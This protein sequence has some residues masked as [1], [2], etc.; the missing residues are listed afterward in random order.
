MK[1]RVLITGASGLLGR[2]LVEYSASGWDVRAMTHADLDVSDAPAVAAALESIRPQ[3]VIN[4]AALS[5]VDQCE[6]EPARAFAVNAEGPY[7]LARACR[8]VGADLVQISTDYVFDG[9]KGTPYTLEDTPHPLNLYG[10]SKLAGE[11]AVRQTLDRYYIVRPARIFGVGGRNFATQI[12]DLIAAHRPIRAIIDEVG[13]PTYVR[14]LAERIFRIVEQG[15]PGIYH[16]TN[17]GACSWYDFAREVLRLLKRDDL[18]VEPVRSADLGR[19]ARRPAMTALRCLLSESL[20][21]EPLRPWAE[22]YADF[23]AE[24]GIV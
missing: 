14:D 17:G 19:P 18:L 20:G 13:S 16:V 3:V 9:T 2:A 7:H 23:L 15:S 12:V 10:Q 4:C 8:R 6:R 21:W 11:E 5:H 1:R 24:V 22:A